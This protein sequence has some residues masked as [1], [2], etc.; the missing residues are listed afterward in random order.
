MAGLFGGDTYG[1][2]HLYTTA[3]HIRPRAMIDSSFAS[4]T[5]SRLINVTIFSIGS[6]G[7]NFVCPYG[8]CTNMDGCKGPFG[9]INLSNY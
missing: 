2:K 7:N 6:F 9:Q 4:I 5:P 1:D 8:R 3:S